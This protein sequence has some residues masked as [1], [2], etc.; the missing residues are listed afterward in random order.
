[1]LFESAWQELCERC[2]SLAE[3]AVFETPSTNRILTVERVADGEIDV[4]SP[5]RDEPRT[6]GRDRFRSLY[7]ELSEES[8]GR[9]LADFPPGAEP[10]ATLL[11]LLPEIHVTTDRLVYDD[12]AVDS[13]T[14][15][16]KPSW[17]ERSGPVRLHDDA[18]LLAAL[19]DRI[20]VD[21]ARAEQ[22]VDL[23]V[24]LSDVQHEA[25]DLRETVRD[26]LLAAMDSSD[27]IEGRFGSV[28]RTERTRREPLDTET[29]FRE[30][31]DRDIPRD[32]VLDVDRQKLDVVV[33]VTELAETDVYDVETETYVQ[34]TDISG[35]EREAHLR[36]LE[37]Q[38]AP[39]DGERAER[40]HDEVRA[41]EERLD[42]LLAAG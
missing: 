20:D 10:Y 24:L 12:S 2:R 31:D 22:L 19:L 18:T 25:G 38:L 17:E 5:S 7:Q 33:A 23:Y 27:R 30:L 34:K 28:T 8:D 16:L 42:S 6:L 41:L 35:I 21:A 37:D 4:N 15:L 32:W 36:R 1:M 11:T 39:L 9:E 14:P 26:E 13:G 40:L 3:G 29:I